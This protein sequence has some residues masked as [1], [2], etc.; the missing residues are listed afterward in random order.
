MTFKEER[1]AMT[2]RAWE[3]L[4]KRLEQDGLLEDT[5]KTRPRTSVRMLTY[6]TAAAAAVLCIFIVSAVMLYNRRPSDDR[7]SLHNG[8]G[9]PTL[10]KKM[11]DGSVI[12]LSEHTS[13]QYPEH[14]P[15]D[16]REIFL[17]GN[18]FFE[19]TGNRERPFIVETKSGMVEVIGTAFNIESKKENHLSV[20]VCSGKVKVTS[21][22]EGKSVWVSAGETVA[23]HSGSMIKQGLQDDNLF[24]KYKQ[25]IHFK[26]QYLSDV[27]NILNTHNSEA[28]ITLLPEVEDRL[29][30]VTF[31][32]D[33]PET[34]VELICMAL[35]LKFEHKGNEIFIAP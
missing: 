7:L 34:N 31:T 13:I 33:S 24:D 29:L 23:I 19:V 5:E 21:K 11:E 30:T 16:K 22:K 25:R 4:Y 15:E 12:Y 32:D 18:A 35:N 27:I 3:N 1:S 20:S 17:Q 28:R 2:D 14:F 8:P 9:K 10:V 6:R 26:D